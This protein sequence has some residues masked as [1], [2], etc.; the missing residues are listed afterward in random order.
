MIQCQFLLV[1]FV[2]NA[3]DPAVYDLIAVPF[4]RETTNDIVKITFLNKWVFLQSDY[5]FTNKYGNIY[6]K[7]NTNVS[8]CC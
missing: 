5:C 7:D 1:V 6:Y 8:V 2:V 3:T 4:K